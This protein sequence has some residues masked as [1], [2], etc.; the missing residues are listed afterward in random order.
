[1]PPHLP[2]PIW[3]AHHP[4]LR[5][6]CVPCT[7]ILVQIAVIGCGHGKLDS[8]YA[9]VKE[10]ELASGKTVDLVIINGDFQAIRNTA[11]LDNISVPAKYRVLG[12]FHRYYSGQVT[13]PYLTMFIGGNHES[14]AYLWELYHGGWAARN[15]YFMGW[16]NVIRVGSL[17]IGG[18]SGVWNYHSFTK[19]HH[20]QAPY[21]PDQIRSI[22]HTR[23]H[24]IMQLSLVR[25]QSLDVFLS[26]DWPRNIAF[27]GD[28]EALLTEKPFLTK[29]CIR[30]GRLGSPAMEH[31]LHHLQ[32][33]Y[34]FAG[35]L[36]VQ[37][38]AI[39]SHSTSNFATTPDI[40]SFSHLRRPQPTTM[41]NAP[42]PATRVTRF[43]ALDKAEPNRQFLQVLEI[44]GSVG[45]LRYDLDWLAIVKATHHLMPRHANSQPASYNWSQLTAAVEEAKVELL[46]RFGGGDLDGH[47]LIPDAQTSFA[48]TG[49]V[50]LQPLL[51]D[52]RQLANRLHANPQTAMFAQWLG[53]SCMTESGVQ[54][55]EYSALERQ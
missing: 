8:I 5:S 17:R 1:M 9:S 21:S 22:Y 28:M 19:G 12:D 38:P 26:H 50:H 6:S 43:L 3:P 42:D 37:F 32:P 27:H 55:S 46:R 2:L 44:E 35:H 39:V 52:H 20:E 54:C 48:V 16:A 53:I 47:L 45:P 11:D 40:T 36:H 41:H 18:T 24:E 23:Q 7:C 10:S 33:R 29:M 34:W 13:A 15:I 14:S 30:S 51:E 31:L 25:Q 4:K 49:P